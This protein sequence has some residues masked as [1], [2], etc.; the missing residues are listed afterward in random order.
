MD[1]IQ[2]DPTLRAYKRATSLPPGKEQ[3]SEFHSLNFDCNNN[4]MIH[5]N[6]EVPWHETNPEEYG[7]LAVGSQQNYPQVNKIL[8]NSLSL[9]MLN[10]KKEKKEDVS[11]TAETG[12]TGQESMV[13]YFNLRQPNNLTGVFPPK[14]VFHERS[15]NQEELSPTIFQ[16]T[17]LMADWR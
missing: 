9:P 10:G 15:E 7:I 6:G 2:G 1:L 8:F 12:L 14:V 13:R 17:S 16:P 3:K 11:S 4:D 5:M